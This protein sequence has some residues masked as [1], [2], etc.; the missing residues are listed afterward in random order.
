MIL[1]ESIPELVLVPLLA[2]RRSEN[3]LRAL[4]ARLLHVVERKVQILRTCLSIDRQTAIASLANFFERI[5]AAQMDDI[6]RRSGHLGQCD[7]AGRSLSL[8]GRRTRE[9]VI[10]GSGLALGQR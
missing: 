3:I 1:L 6:H 4:E 9:R 5:V 8:G 2:Q 10:F 7:G